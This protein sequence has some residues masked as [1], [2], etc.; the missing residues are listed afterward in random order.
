MDYFLGIDVGTG[1]ARAGV[2]Q[3]NGALVGTSSRPITRFQPAPDFA[4]QSSAEIWSAICI[5]V[6]EAMEQGSI[7]PDAIKGIGFDATCSLVLEDADG[8]PVSVSPNGEAEQD[9]VM[10]LDHRANGDADAINKLDAEQLKYV[11]GIISPEMQMPKLRWLKRELPEAW[12]KAASFWDLPDWL[13][14]RAT[15]TDTRSLCSTV[16]KWAYLGQKGTSGEGWDKD[17][18]KTIGLDDLA[19]DNFKALGQT[20]SVAGASVGQ[21]SEQA[22]GELGLV[23]GIPVSASL[24]DAYAG[25]LGTLGAMPEQ[26]A[27]E[28]RMAVIAG[29]STCHIAVNPEAAFVPGVWGPYHSVLL[30]DMWA[31]EGGQSAAGALIDAVIARHAQ[32]DLLRKRAEEKGTSIYAEMEA[33]LAEMG[34]ETAVL[35]ANRHVQP[36][37]HGNR[38]PLADPTRKGAISGLSLDVGEKD[39]AL[40]YLATVQALSYG[41]RHVLE[42]MQANGAPVSIMV[43]SGGLAKNKLFLREMA[44]ATGCVI[45]VPD[46]Q[47]PV[48][49]GSAMIGAVAA[50]AFENLADAMAKMSGE[51]QVIN[52]R[53]GACAD[54][55]DRKYRVFRRMQEDFAAY[56]RI[57]N[58]KEEEQ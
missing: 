40:D 37:F 9:I 27:I 55:H 49:L 12:A 44:D 4:Q 21:L 29:T 26:G 16:C 8:N 3:K 2:F 34:D 52:P 11:G 24:I 47:E 7:A 1:S 10:W 38:A 6:K 18:L 14:H 33:I 30:P 31:L 13:A 58:S 56:D 53:G 25:A 45:L 39:L 35:T 48:L 57:M 20:L 54:Y 36:D 43:V 19:D 15:G 23:A 51:G 46:Q 32:A 22:A 41:T 17:F 28:A 42:E 50:G 5:S